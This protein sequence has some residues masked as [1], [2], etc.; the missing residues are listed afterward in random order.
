ME[1]I[2]YFRAIGRRFWLLILLP[3]IGAAIPGALF[4][5][6]PALYGATAT[7]TAPTLVGGVDAETYD[8]AEA[9]KQFAGDIQGA[10]GL[11]EVIDQISARTGVSRHD[12]TSGLHSEAIGD[13]T[14][15]QV[16]F[17]T[18][19]RAKAAPVARAAAEIALDH[20]FSSQVQ[21]AK[22]PFDAA[23]ADAKR[24][25]E[26]LADF[27]RQVA[28]PDPTAS[29]IVKQRSQAQISQSI[30][31]HLASGDKSAADR[32]AA[33]LEAGKAQVEVLRQQVVQYQ[34][35]TDGRNQAKISRD[36]REK[37][38]QSAK[39]QLDAADPSRSLRV[40]RPKHV[41][42][43]STLLPEVGGGMA[44]GVFLSILI[45]A[46]VDIRGALKAKRA[47]RTSRETLISR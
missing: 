7:I 22:A 11:K 3:V 32:E 19:K 4:A 35:L 39:A 34:S 37:A 28:T 14:F 21:I 17:R 6:E 20:L 44:A 41:I 5:S 26:R 15:I 13:S 16:S 25:E 45:T 33:L 30:A 24:T 2:D 9:A 40:G 31:N 23:T 47:L 27:L 29:Y 38:F 8:G 46:L 42:P 10:L 12:L 18:T 1:I 36:E 43:V